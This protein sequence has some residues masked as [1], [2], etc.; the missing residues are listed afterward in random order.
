MIFVL[1]VLFDVLW[2]PAAC[3]L[4]ARIVFLARLMSR[5]E[6]MVLDFV[7]RLHM[8]SVCLLF[9]IVTSHCHIAAGRVCLSP[10]LRRSD[11]RATFAFPVVVREAHNHGDNHHSSYKS[12]YACA[13]V[14]FADFTYH[15]DHHPHHRIQRSRSLI[16]RTPPG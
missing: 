11:F 9:F 16:Y 2:L 7:L 3:V 5:N 10:C 13:V 6:R 4:I 12:K 1:I 8:S 15:S 14:F